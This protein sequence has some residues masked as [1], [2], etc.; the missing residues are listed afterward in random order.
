[1]CQCQTKSVGVGRP[2]CTD[3]SVSQQTVNCHNANFCCRWWPV[4][5]CRP[6]VRLALWQLS[7]FS[8]CRFKC[9]WWRFRWRRCS[10]RCCRFICS[11]CRC[12]NRSTIIVPPTGLMTSGIRAVNMNIWINLPTQRL[13][14][15][16]KRFLTGAQTINWSC[17]RFDRIV[18]FN[19]L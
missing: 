9:S 17:W 2:Q 5:T 1:M 3:I 13:V 8:G 4:T 12:S 6:T 18:K 7:V 15:N 19:S 14:L 10:P 11:R 16:L